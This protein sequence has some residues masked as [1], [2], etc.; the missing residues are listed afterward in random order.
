M[1][2][3]QFSYGALTSYQKSGQ[4]LPVDG[5][6]DLEGNPTRDPKAI[7][8][9]GRPFPIGYWKGSGLAILLDLMAAMLS[10]GQ[11]THQIERDSERETG[12][13]QCFIAVNVVALDQN[14]LA[15]RIADQIIESVRLPNHKSGASVRYP[16]ERVL[17]TRM[18][19]L[20]QGI[21]VER[22]DWDE[23]MKI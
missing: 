8:A 11:A 23:L 18:E 20:Q 15:D 13:S 1:A 12:L 19:N 14:S 6:Y 16:G 7:E 5:G 17:Q 21:P 22:S 3:S 2:M 10:G 9:S 4:P